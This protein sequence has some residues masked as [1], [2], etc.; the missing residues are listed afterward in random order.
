MTPTPAERVFR[1]SLDLL[2]AKD[3]DG[4]VALWADDGVF[5]FPFALPEGTRRLEG[6][7][8]VRA[9]IDGYPG[10]IDL[11]RFEDLV[12]HQTTDPE[13]VVAELRGVGRAVATGRPYDM[14]YVC[15]VTVRDGEIVR[16]RD[17]WNG[18]LVA[19][20]FEGGLPIG[21]RT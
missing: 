4:W 20:A 5:E 15:V 8:A 14:P 18:A 9:Y 6:R 11:H 17:Y 19:D 1:H 10:H 13:V 2:L 3:I 21:A 16:Y 12:I 7:D